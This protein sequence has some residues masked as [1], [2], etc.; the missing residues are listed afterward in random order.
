VVSRQTV[1]LEKDGL[2]TRTQ[3][4]HK[5]TLLTLEITEKGNDIIKTARHSKS[6]NAIF[7]FLSTEER[8]QMES[9]LYRIL[10]E[11]KKYNRD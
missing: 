5:S 2:I 9:T 11:V 6:I 1:S 10:V 4:T 8:Q 7:S 3:S